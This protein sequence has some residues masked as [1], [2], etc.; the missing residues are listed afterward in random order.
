L[1]LKND[2]PFSKLAVNFNLRRYA[3]GL[4]FGTAQG[5]VVSLVGAT[6]AAAASFAVTRREAGGSLISSTIIPSL[7]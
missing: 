6:A 3:A 2:G 7:Q 4:F 1:D 5:A